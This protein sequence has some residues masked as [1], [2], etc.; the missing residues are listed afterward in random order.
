MRQALLEW[1]L[2]MLLHVLLGVNFPPE[3]FAEV[4]GLLTDTL[5]VV[6]ILSR[7]ALEYLSNTTHGE[8]WQ[9]VVCTCIV[10]MFLKK[11]H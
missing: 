2:A 5:Q 1:L 11:A 3:F 6:E 4:F 7:Y 10:Q 9:V 8:F